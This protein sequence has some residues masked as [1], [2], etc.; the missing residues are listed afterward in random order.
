MKTI[1]IAEAGVNHNGSVDLACQLIEAAADCGADFVK[2]QTF[3]ADRLATKNAKKAEYQ[4]QNSDPN[5]SHYEM[6]RSLELSIGAHEKLIAH[7][8]KCKINFLSS[9]F[10]IEGIDLLLRLKQSVFKVPSG[11]INNYP[12][13]RYLGSLK[14]RIILSTGMSTLGD[15]EAAI[16][17]LVGA[18]ASKEDIKILHCTSEYP[19][20][21]EDVNLN[22]I[23]TIRNAFN[24][25]VGYSDHSVGIEVAI[26][27][28]AKGAIII[29]KHFTLD[30]SLPG[31][32]HKASLEPNELEKMIS[33]IR[34]VELALGDGVKRAMPSE[35]KNLA[36]ARKSIVASRKIKSGDIFTE[37][38]IAVK[39]PGGGISPMRWEEILGKR[40]P[41]NFEIDEQIF[42]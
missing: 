17:I 42:L 1:I 4:I 6:L 22:A 13:L 19:A 31:P 37:S 39:R 15:I 32:D 26:A 10:D 38:N 16:N 18:G 33:S 20:P 35:L 41:N 9:P 11:E 23:Q 36:V 2:F 21:F 14:K 30:R 34:N 29:E 7:C 8:A 24:V 27:A 25:D 3:N 40:A 28:V 12:Y 5:E